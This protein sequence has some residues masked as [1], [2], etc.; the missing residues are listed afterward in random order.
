MLMGSSCEETGWPHAAPVRF[1][2][3][4]D[5]EPTT[6]GEGDGAG[7]GALPSGGTLRLLPHGSFF[8]SFP[9]MRVV[10]GGLYMRHL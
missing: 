4:L 1:V 5:A 7:D 10:L 2:G 9:I 6:V 3:L 8:L